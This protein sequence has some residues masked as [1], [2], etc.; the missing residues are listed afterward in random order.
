MGNRRGEGW[1]GAAFWVMVVVFGDEGVCLVVVMMFCG[2]IG[3][4]VVM[5]TRACGLDREFWREGWLLLLEGGSKVV[6]IFFSKGVSM[7]L[8][9]L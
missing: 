9:Y 3:L 5:C 8:K 2:V 4:V 7:F 1:W 6:M